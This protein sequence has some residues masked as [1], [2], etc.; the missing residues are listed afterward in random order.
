MGSSKAVVDG[1]KRATST[2]D[3]IEWIDA[4]FDWAKSVLRHRKPRLSLWANWRDGIT[5]DEHFGVIIKSRI[6]K[7]FRCE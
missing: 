4:K 6:G 1:G 3:L 2:P 7:M 5:H